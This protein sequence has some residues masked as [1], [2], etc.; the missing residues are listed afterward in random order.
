MG[1]KEIRAT[2]STSTV[3]V[4]KIYAVYTTLFS[5]YFGALCYPQT[6]VLEAFSFK[7]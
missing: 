4:M 2:R 6:Q 5:R 7:F 1:N 3:Q